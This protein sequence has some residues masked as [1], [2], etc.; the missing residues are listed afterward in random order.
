M[1]FISQATMRKC[2]Q[3][4]FEIGVEYCYFVMW[5]MNNCSLQLANSQFPPLQLFV[6]FVKEYKSKT[7]LVKVYG[8]MLAQGRAINFA[9]GPLL[10]GCV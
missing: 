5:F 6:F 2:F 7:L 8:H 9:R 4:V 10:E 3:F 1:A